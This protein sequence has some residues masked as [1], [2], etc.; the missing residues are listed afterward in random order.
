MLIHQFHK[1][2]NPLDFI[3]IQRICF[4]S[5]IHIFTT[6][7]NDFDFS[8]FIPI[9]KFAVLPLL[10]FFSEIPKTI[11]M[12]HNNFQRRFT[13]CHSL[14]PLFFKIRIYRQYD[15]AS[16]SQHFLTVLE[17]SNALQR[18]FCRNIFDNS[19]L[20]LFHV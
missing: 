13:V 8:N 12:R 1:K 4:L 2:T 11:I 10:Q 15:L 14:R 19:F 17:R 5:V 18:F 20:N 3:S 9:W 7:I 16:S 6:R